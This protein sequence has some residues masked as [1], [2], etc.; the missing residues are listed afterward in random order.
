LNYLTNEYIK[1]KLGIT[2]FSDQ[3]KIILDWND[4]FNDGFKAVEVY[5]ILN[6]IGIDDDI[7]FP[8]LTSTN[9]NSDGNYYFGK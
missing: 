2:Y 5:T 1:A 3:Q 9:F 8:I 7:T 6:E 4:K